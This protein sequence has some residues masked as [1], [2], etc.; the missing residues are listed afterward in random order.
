ML[1]T[2]GESAALATKISWLVIKITFLPAAGIVKAGAVVENGAK[3][4]G[5][6]MATGP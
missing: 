1:A 6:T 4:V 3:R 5:Y 2:G